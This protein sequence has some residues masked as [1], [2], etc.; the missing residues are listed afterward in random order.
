MD[1]LYIL[2]NTEQIKQLKSKYFYYLDHKDWNGWKT[3]VFSA[4]ATMEC[5]EDRPDIVEGIDDI[6]AYLIRV[7][8]GVLTVHHGHM[9][10]IQITSPTTAKGIWA[11]EDLLFVPADKCPDGKAARLHGY[12]HYHETYVLQENGWR[13][14][15]LRLTRLLNPVK[16]LS[17]P[18]EWKGTL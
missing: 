2:Q 18:E 11:M 7:V 16:L 1:P 9:P 6:I 15:S 17:E 10:N 14:K 4:E 5:K 3:E 12:G 8:T 13:I